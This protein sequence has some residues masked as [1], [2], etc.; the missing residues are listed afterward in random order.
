MPA[1]SAECVSND[2]GEGALAPGAAG[3][4][5]SL[6][7]AAAELIQ[8]ERELLQLEQATASA[9]QA[10]PEARREG[11][12]NLIH[13][14][15]LRQRDLRELQG[16]LSQLG[17]SSLG[18]T[19]SCVLGGVLEVSERVHEALALRDRDGAREELA[20]ITAA[21]EHGLAWDAARACLHAHSLELFGARPPDRHIYI[22]VTAPSAKEADRA[23]MTKLLLAGMNVLRINCAHEGEVEWQS[24]IEALHS[25]RTE[26]GLACRVLMD[27]AGPKIRTGKI[28]RSARIATWKPTRDEIGQPTAPARVVIRRESAPHNAEAPAMLWIADREFERLRE[29]DEIRFRDARDK[30]RSLYIERLGEQELVATANERAYVLG[31]A[32]AQIR[33]KEKHKDDVSLRVAEAAEAAIDV[34]QGDSLRLTREDIAG[35]PPRRDDEGKVERPGVIS[36][37]LP[38]ALDHLKVG[39]RVLFDDGKIHAQ[40]ESAEEGG[41]EFVLRVVRTHKAASKLRGEKGINLPDSQLTVPGLTDD[42]RRALTFVVQ[43]ADA[44]SMSFVRTTED[45]QAL[46]LEL[47]RLGRPDLGVVLKIETREGFENLPRLLL[48]GLKGQALGVMIARGDLAVEVGFERVAE[49]QEEMLWLCE[50]AHVPVIWATQVLDGLARDG[51]PSRAEVTDASASVAAECVMLNKGPF[52]DEAVKVLAEILRRMEKHRYKKRSLFRKLQVSHFE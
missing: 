5:E 7:S 41:A 15:A 50:A 29:G 20:R 8:L 16:R 22:M 47:G 34:R 13:Y 32:D 42:D 44:V 27:L 23:W 26:T 9:W 39:H 31:A 4:R 36:C 18:R 49:L 21:R 52:V 51:F 24:M 48:E 37:T 2:L 33:R 12:R 40:V 28:K 35:K 3:V 11:A 25:A 43:H 46:H 14:L 1:N 17:L 45:V 30:K 38:A 19:E 10:V 6:S